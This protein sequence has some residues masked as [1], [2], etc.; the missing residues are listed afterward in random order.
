MDN[1]SIIL[2]CRNESLNLKTLLPELQHY[3]PQAEIIL[4]NDGSTD[5]SVQ[6]ATQHNVRVISHPYSQGNGA[7]VKTGAR[8]A[9]GD[10]LIFMDA[11]G[12]HN[13]V[14]IQALLEKL[15]KGYDMVVGARRSESQ[16]SL[17]RWFAN[18]FY[19]RLASW[20]VGHPI[21]DLTSGFRAVKADKFR[22]FLFL[23][24][25]SFSYPS[26]ITM[27][28]FRAGY[29]IDYIPIVARKR[30]GKSHIRPLHDGGR[31]LMI[32]FKIGTLYAPMKLFLPLSFSF[33]SL[34]LGYYIYT[35]L[36]E[37]RFTNMGMLL[38]VTAILIFLIGLVSEQITQLLYSRKE[39]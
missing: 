4:V 26:T 35:F 10:I 38:F 20:I 12:Q 17:G 13:P 18:I 3:C 11:D 34:G 25:N 27:A 33:F 22:E 23:L 21:A 1:V 30:Q 37:G 31:F 19:N 36:T 24:P 39:K 6:I 15:N 32:I 28:F 14:D 5:D 29:A 16:A 8:I 2:P 9:K 7:A